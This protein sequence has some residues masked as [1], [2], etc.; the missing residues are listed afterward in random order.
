[1]K[2]L[3]SRLAALVSPVDFIALYGD[4]GAG[5]TTFAQGLLPALGVTEA[6]TSPTYGLVHSYAAGARTVNHCDFFRLSPGEEEET[7][8]H[9]M[10][11]S[12]IVVAEW[13]EAIQAVLP[14]NR[15]EVRIEGEGPARGVSLAGFG[16]WESK[17]ARFREIEAFLARN[18]WGD[19][20]CAAVRGDASAR[21]FS[22]LAYAGD[23]LA[24]GAP[25]TEGLSPHP[26]PLPLGEG[27]ARRPPSAIQA[28][29]LPGGEGQ[30]EGSELRA[31]H[32]PR[33]GKTVMLMDW[34][35]RPDGPP[36]RDGRPYCEIAHLARE[37]SPFLA[38]SE[39]LRGKAGIS[40]PAILA[41]DLGA[42]LFLVEDLGDSVFGQLIADGAHVEPLYGLA[43]DGLLAIRASQPP[44]AL[45]MAGGATYRVPE[46][47]REAL[48][49]EL[50]LLLQWY[51]KLETGEPASPELA[52][53]F[54][55][56]WSPYLDWLDTQPKDLV[57]RDYHSPNLLL[58]ESRSGLRRLGA[59]DFQ[60]AVWGHAAYDL[61]SLLQDA[62]LDV[63][64]AAERALFERY[65][66]GA[67]KADPSFDRASF[68]KAYAVLGAQRNT[69][70]AGIFARLSMRDGKH[71]YLAHLPRI[72][73]YLFRNLAHPDLKPLGAWYEAHLR[74]LEE[75]QREQGAL[76]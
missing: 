41:S 19:A 5:K 11:A 33:A 75:T 73:R 23:V 43:V 27:T 49:I 25:L 35:P 52:A 32:A 42:G 18:G 38:I 55:S 54:F 3:A 39:W 37:G 71:G 8:F 26:V 12:S 29:L 44:Q 2:A 51:F 7:G 47:S 31:G 14:A 36:I 24:R 4:L 64:E 46:Y 50:D 70:I 74:P 9:E 6:V 69:K 72:A 34:P 30:D 1:M 60:D 66:L 10:C 57:L 58:C 56:A 40:A 20:R 53:S 17:L 22:R 61:V 76:R 21:L 59:I 65:C 45:P 16:A 68:A 67:A 15:L 28:S 63:P 13:P 62:R 48:E